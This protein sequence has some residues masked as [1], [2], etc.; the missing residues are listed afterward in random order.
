[1]FYLAW[2]PGVYVIELHVPFG[3]LL[4]VKV[5][6]IRRTS[7]FLKRMDFC[8]GESGTL[9]I[10]LLRVYADDCPRK[11]QHV[12]S[13]FRLSGMYSRTAA[14]AFDPKINFQ[15]KCLLATWTLKVR[16]RV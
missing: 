1:M 16:F 15:D 12:I 6:G 11:Y 8:V 14:Y 2:G 9:N 10:L 4:R 5:S 3:G 7:A 13:G